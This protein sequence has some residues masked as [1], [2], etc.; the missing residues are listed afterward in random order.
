MSVRCLIVDDSPVMR[1]LLSGLLQRDH[2]IDVIGTAPN[3]KVARE[4]IKELNPDVITL[5]IEMPGMNGLDFLEKLMLLR[6]MPVVM[7]STLTTKGAEATLRA[8]EIGAVDYYAKPEGAVQD[9]L[10]VDDGQL[11]D[12]V[13]Q[14]A[15]S[16]RRSLPTVRHQAR[17]DEFRW[18]GNYLAIG[19][20]T[21]GVEALTELLENFPADCPP[22]V[23][24]QH[25]PATFTASFA[26]RLDKNCRATIVEATDGV[27]LRPGTVYIAPGGNSHMMVKA[28]S[29]PFCRLVGGD[30]VTGHRPSVDVLFRSMA[31]AF[32][33]SAVGIILTGM[34]RDGASGLLELR[35]SGARTVGQDE[36]SC[37]VYGMPRVAAEIGACEFVLPLEAISKKA[38]DL[39]SI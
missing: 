35:Q 24:V 20:S 16:R 7:C 39:C 34:G 13:K 4:M 26:A 18:N 21:G 23:V 15:R 32:G 3:T 38:L 11:A 27:Q 36:A 33:S 8:L 9:L 1:A 14:A 10:A 29:N 17:S 2:D 19:A 25:M 30:L 5:D 31:Q 6:P 22:T 28:G 12:L 37:V